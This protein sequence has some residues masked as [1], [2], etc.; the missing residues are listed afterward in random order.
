MSP[1]SHSHVRTTA[2]LAQFL[3]TTGPPESSVSPQRQLLA[4]LRVVGKKKSNH[5]M[6]NHPPAY[7]RPKHIPLPVYQPPSPPSFDENQYQYQHHPSTTTTTGAPL[8]KERSDDTIAPSNDE[9][10][11]MDMM[12]NSNNNNECPYCHSPRSH[13]RRKRRTSCPA[14][15]KYTPAQSAKPTDNLT[16]QEAKMLFTMIERLQMQLAREQASRRMLEQT[17]AT[18]KI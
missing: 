3:S 14:A 4:R 5:S 9:R 11:G 1:P 17:L 2:A 7:P 16:S 13:Q 15:I 10:E 8:E 12:D 18:Q 6:N